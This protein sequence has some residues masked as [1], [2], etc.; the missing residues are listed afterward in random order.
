MYIVDSSVLIEYGVHVVNLNLSVRMKIQV[1]PFI[2][3]VHITMNLMVFLPP[4]GPE[5]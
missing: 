5:S 4:L 2:G 1:L 3:D